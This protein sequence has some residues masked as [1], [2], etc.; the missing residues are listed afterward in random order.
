M[1]LYRLTLAAS[2]QPHDDERFF[3]G[4]DDA[5]DKFH[6]T[7][8]LSVVAGEDEVATGYRIA[9]ALEA[10]GFLRVCVAASTTMWPTRGSRITS[11]KTH[12][13]WTFQ[14]WEEN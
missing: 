13:G 10:K 5:Y 7:V 12:N 6:E 2:E 4:P 1:Q 9:A 3:I 11:L 8:R 14:E